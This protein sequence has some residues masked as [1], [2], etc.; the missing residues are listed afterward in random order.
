V[1]SCNQKFIS[2]FGHML[3]HIRTGGVRGD[4]VP[5]R[6]YKKL[7]KRSKDFAVFDQHLYKLHPTRQAPPRL[8]IEDEAEKLQIME[9]MHEELGHKGV[10][11]TLQ[12]VLTHYWW[13]GVASYVE[14]H[15]QTCEICQR[16][17]HIRYE[18]PLVPTLIPTMFQAVGIDTVKVTVQGVGGKTMMLVARE[19]LSGWVEIEAVS[20]ATARLAAQFIAKLSYRYGMIPMIILDGGPEFKKDVST[21]LTTMGM[22]R[23]NISVAHPQANGVVERGH[24]SLLQALR[25]SCYGDEKQW[26]RLV[27]KLCF[28][29]NSTANRTTGYCPHEMVYG[30]KAL[31]PVENA[32]VS[33][34]NIDWAQCW[35]RE[36]L[37]AGRI[38]QLGGLVNLRDTAVA[39]KRKQR[40]DSKRRFDASKRL[41]PT[42]ASILV[43]DLVLRWDYTREKQW[44]RKMDAKWVGPY[45]VVEALISGAYRLAE[46][47]GTLLAR[48]TAGRHVKKFWERKTGRYTP[49]EELELAAAGMAV[50]GGEQEGSEEDAMA[51][52]IWWEAEQERQADA[53]R[54]DMEDGALWEGF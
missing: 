7:K 8:V 11:S 47:D 18:E 23:I 28:V 35:T 54:Q 31:Y 6:I 9:V 27:P 25:K 49:A 22:W 5:S 21:L 45:R 19:L 15:V 13:P 40:E 38:E 52:E 14:D 53:D 20:E 1:K 50:V 3:N 48:T 34:M 33:F 41:R 16:F 17:S 29:E 39:N 37:L 26:P 4:G 36:E 42:G 24:S 46:L 43:G 51:Q 2:F 30:W 32:S 12:R 44:S 10:H